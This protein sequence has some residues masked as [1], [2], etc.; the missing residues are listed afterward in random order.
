ML[1]IAGGCGTAVYEAKMAATLVEFQ[2][3]LANGADQPAA[4]D[5]GETA[6]QPATEE[7]TG[8]PTGA[9]QPAAEE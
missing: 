6:S 9:D 5:A 4:E 3:S 7:A 2:Q 1:F 8:E